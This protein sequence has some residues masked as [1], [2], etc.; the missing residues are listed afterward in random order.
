MSRALLVAVLLVLAGCNAPAGEPTVGESVTAAP[1][2]EVPTTATPAGR[3]APG[4]RDDGVDGT[5]LADAHERALANAS[6]TV[7]QTLVR[8]YAN[9]SLRWRYV[10]VGRFGATPGRFA[11]VLDRTD[12]EDGALRTRTVRRY[13]DG[14]R[15]YQSV[16][17]GNTTTAGLLRWPEGDPRDPGDVYPDR[18][19]NARAI[20]RVFTL[21]E[22]RRTGT[23]V[24]NGT[25][26]A[27][28]ESVAN[29]SVPPLWNVTVT[30]LVSPEGLVREYRVAYDVTRDDGSV[31]SVVALSYTR[32]GETRVTP[33]PWVE[34]IRNE[35]TERRPLRPLS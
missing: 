29:A 21:V 2:P 31:R 28:I 16:T 33:P 26:Y 32:V 15:A 22:T 4:V 20:E 34:S 9:G 24:V 23:V 25:R 13:G 6:Y 17:E 7:N 1:V 12:R 11:T 18:L 30:A 35:T 8:R 27:R 19:T 5:R 3:F 10:T 14:E